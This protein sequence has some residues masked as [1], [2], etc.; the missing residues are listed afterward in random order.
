MSTTETTPNADLATFTVNGAE[1]QAPKGANLL[2]TL[3]AAGY[4]IPHYCYHPALSVDGTCRL[5]FVQME[6]DPRLHV[7]CN[8][9]V[10]DGL[11]ILT[12]T[13]TIHEA[14]QGMMEFLLVNHP[15]DCPVCDKGGECLLQRYSMDHGIGDARMSDL[16]RRYP[17]PQF[18]PLIDLERNRCILCSRCVRFCDEIAENHVLGIVERGDRNR[19]A[20]FGDGPIASIY[21]GN[22]VDL[23]PVGALTSKPF[24]FH[25][26]TWEMQQIVTSCV[27]CSSGCAMTAWARDGKVLRVTTPVV[28]KGDGYSLNE[29]TSD[30]ICNVGRFASDFGHDDS[31]IT[32][33]LV[34]RDGKMTSAG[35]A[36][37]IDAAAQLLKGVAETHGAESVAFL[38]SP[39]ATNE[40]LFLLQHI[41]RQGVGSSNI[42]WRVNLA[43]A[44]ACAAHSALMAASDG[45]VG[46]LESVDVVLVVEAALSATTPILALKVKEAAK[47]GRNQTIQLGS[48]IDP[49]VGK[50]AARNI[51]RPFGEIVAL[52]EQAIDPASGNGDA[53]ANA[54]FS[55]LRSAGSGM[56][57]VGL[58]EQSGMLL[59]SLAPLVLRLKESLGAAWKLMAVA[60]ERNA[61]GAFAAGCQPD[62]E[63]GHAA[64]VKGMAAPEIIDAAASG[65]IKAL[66]VQGQDLLALCPDPQAL[67][68]AFAAVEVLIVQTSYPGPATEKATVVLPGALFTE[69][70]G[71]FAN[72]DGSLARLV[73]G[74]D[75]PAGVQDDLAILRSLAEAL[76]VCSGVR[77]AADGFAQFLA[78]IDGSVSFTLDDLT[79]DQP[80]EEWPLRVR[81][82]IGQKVRPSFAIRFGEAVECAATCPA[83]RA[84]MSG[85]DSLRARWSWDVSRGD[86]LADRSPTMSRLRPRHSSVY[87]NPAAARD[88][89]L[90]DRQSITVSCEGQDAVS[91]MLHVSEGVAPGV[92]HVAA[93]DFPA[94]MLQRVLVAAPAAE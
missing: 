57:L 93:N 47:H 85:T 91:A 36:E 68:K 71:S 21:S 27:Y 79:A 92:V 78:Q 94:A 12:E 34:R 58:S 38:A 14:R 63:V 45:T 81:A 31:R 69:K 39:R 51:V 88:L 82:E 54:L 66:Y 11:K 41:A 50:H 23:C 77:T 18:D 37:A 84:T 56:I 13:D 60:A 35:T 53:E 73:K 90:A 46:D 15:L 20:S 74:Y 86:H 48:V 76:G 43:D 7:S 89:G 17:K 80:G 6:G 52:L 70:D 64:K 61:V 1:L 10:A 25:A 83:E 40:E 30:F 28:R 3:L 67:Q 65:Q 24:R 16:R 5:C 55:A 9:K 72:V 29:D 19:I 2:R 62:R 22:V 8:M 49:L 59:P 32:N 4:K 44:K 33:A 42:D 75:P 87:M 26:R